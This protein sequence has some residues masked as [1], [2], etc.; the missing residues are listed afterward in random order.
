MLIYIKEIQ[1]GILV[2]GMETKIGKPGFNF[3]KGYL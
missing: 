1:D 3:G 2:I